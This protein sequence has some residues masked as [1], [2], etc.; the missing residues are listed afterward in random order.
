MPL[1]VGWVGRTNRAHESD[2]ERLKLLFRFLA[3]CYP[4]PVIELVITT[5][6]PVFRDWFRCVFSG[7]WQASNGCKSHVVRVRH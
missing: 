3:V 5:A 1:S 2:Q 4:L 6:K 7:E